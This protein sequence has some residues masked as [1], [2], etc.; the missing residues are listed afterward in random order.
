M[1]IGYDAKRLYNNFTGLG[2]Y[3]RF[4][5]DGIHRSFP[6]EEIYLFTPSVKNHPEIKIYQNDSS[7]TTILPSRTLQ[8][9]KLGSYWR[10]FQVK[11]EAKKHQLDVFHGL[12]QELPKK[13]S[14]AT[15]SVV[16]VHDL[17]F[18]RYPQFYQPVDRWIYTQKIKHACKE[19]DVIVAISEQTKNDLI[20][21]LNVPAEKIN[22][23]YQG[24]HPNFKRTFSKEELKQ[25]RQKYQLPEKFLL[26]VG[27]IEPRKNALSI[28][29]ALNEWK[30][31]TS[32]PL[33]IL[34]RPT[35]YLNELNK[36]AQQNNLTNRIQYIHK[37][38][39]IDLPAIYQLSEVFIYPSLFEGFG[40]PL[41]EAIACHTP[42]ITSTGSCFSEAAG[43]ASLYVSPN[44]TSGLA[45]AIEHVLN[46]ESVRQK[47]ISK[48]AEFIQKFESSVIAKNMM[49]VYRSI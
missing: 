27:T 15:K 23:V 8:Q 10:S 40:I 43:P 34:G 31:A 14:S 47:M 48:S 39:F 7:L 28:L 25:V 37:A 2:N 18:I 49:N 32:I 30:D 20:E 26:N 17:I 33:V 16:T 45:N 3:S 29:K 5:V 44:H 13:I 21:F 9:L 36:Y 1:R 19:A 46:D 24:C 38:S 41:V 6:E 12:S 35:H 4:I 11:N 22:V 42:V